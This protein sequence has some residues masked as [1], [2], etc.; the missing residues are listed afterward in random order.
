[1]ALQNQVVKKHSAVTLISNKVSLLQ[2]RAFNV[3]LHNA[4]PLLADTDV[5]E[6]GMP[7]KE[8][9]QK[10]NYK[11]NN[12]DIVK[13]AITGLLSTT[14]SFNILGKYKNK[15][16]ERW[17]ASNLLASAEIERCGKEGWISY[18][19]SHKLRKELIDPKMFT[20]INLYIQNLLNSKHALHLY[21]VCF[22]FRGV[23]TTPKMSYETFREL[24][25]LEE[26]E[27]P[28]FN[29]LNRRIILDPIK[30]INNKTDLFLTPHIKRNGRKIESIQFSVIKN[31]KNIATLPLPKINPNDKQREI[32]FAP[33]HDSKDESVLLQELK[34]TF[35]LPNKQA[36][37]MVKEHG[38]DFVRQKMEMV[39][40]FA[41]RKEVNKSLAALLHSAVKED[42]QESAE[43]QEKRGDKAKVQKQTIAEGALKELLS[44]FSKNKNK[45]AKAVVRGLSKTQIQELIDVDKPNW[46]D[47]DYEQYNKLGAKAPIIKAKV[48][49]VAA[50]DYLESQDNN[51]I[52]YAESQG[53]HVIDHGKENYELTGR[54]G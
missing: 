17:K 39:I 44:D 47:F 4:Q 40:A 12:L 51:F 8:F 16:W 54:F 50:R 1:M 14:V 38:A 25:G 49:T 3:F 2:K 7:L 13:T 20:L 15:T 24:M 42:W 46:S 18:E 52:Q 33:G 37:K 9:L 26:T 27:Y 45:K 22:D 6:F 34:Q 31:E 19:F 11:S 23:E 41:K 35:D 48:E 32:N 28:R 29:D 10:I 36:A 53:F 5:K 30:E 21:E 43:T